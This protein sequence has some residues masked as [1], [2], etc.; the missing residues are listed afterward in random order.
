MARVRLVDVAREVGVS[1]KT[2]SNVVNGTGVVSAEMRE[3]ILATI[4]KLGYR[5]NVA[6][7]ALRTGTSGL[8][9]L[10]LPDLRE[11]YFAEFASSFF[12]VAQRRGLNVVVAQTHGERRAE[13]ALI[14]GEGMPALEGIVM[15]PLALTPQDVSE[16]RSQLPLV[17]IGEHGESLV[18]DRVPQVG[19]DNV[20][21]AA[22]ATRLLVEKGRRR[23]AVIGAQKS[24]STATSRMRLEGYRQALAEAGL[25]FDDALV[26]WV[27]EFNRA[28][29]S[30][31]A[32]RLVRSG[33]Q[34]DGLFCMSDSLVFGALYTLGTHGV[35]VPEDVAVV[36]YDNVEEGRY[37]VPPF[38]TISPGSETSS[39]LIL[40]LIAAARKPAAEPVGGRHVVPFD[41]VDRLA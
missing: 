14:E 17:L 38:A 30:T 39:D 2:V 6:A 11:P 21:A 35:A 18:T 9:A 33:A 40:D 29:G 28:E 15:S 31:A 16:R 27:S 3:R 24:G 8:V 20:A 19:V 32:E 22:A 12:T 10:G 36:G 25:P 7:R 23:I 37:S 4:D 26:G 41:V 5:P 1:A 34:F 13:Q